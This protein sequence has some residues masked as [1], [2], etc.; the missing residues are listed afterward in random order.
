MNMMPVIDIPVSSQV[1]VSQWQW[2][3]EEKEV[4][5]S[6]GFFRRLTIAFNPN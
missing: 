6:Y 3:E 1:Y 2:I 4:M 5:K